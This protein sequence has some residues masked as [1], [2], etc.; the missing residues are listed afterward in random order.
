MPFGLTNAPAT[1]QTARDIMLSGVKWQG[2]LIY[3]DDV[4]VR[5]K[6]EE[7]HIGH[8]NDVLRLLRD[9]GVTFRLT[10]FR[11]FR[12][13]VEYF[14]HELKPGRLGVMDAHTRALR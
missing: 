14:G 8:V 10:K 13:T 4:I 9:A 1:S 6:T 5:S 12:T 11:F 2:C 7:E 3:H